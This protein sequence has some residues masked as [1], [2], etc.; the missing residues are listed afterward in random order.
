MT[1]V[2]T[3]L[4]AAVAAGLGAWLYWVEVPGI[5]EEARRELLLEID[6]DQVEGL[7]L[8]YPEGTAIEVVRQ[9]ES[10]TM[11]EPV[12]YAADASVVR[13]FLTTIQEAKIDRRLAAGESEALASYG[14]EGETGAQARIEVTLEGGKALPAVVLGNTTPVGYQAFARREDSDEVFVIPLLLQSSAK[15][16]PDDL[17]KKTMFDADST[18]VR[19]VTIEKPTERIELERRDDGSWAMLAPLSD[20]ADDEAVRSLL[21]SMATIDALAFFDGDAVD[22]DAFGLDEGA[23][24]FTAERDEGAD[25]A[26]TIGAPSTDPPAG[27]Y[28]ERLSDQQVVKAPDWVVT[29]FAPPAIELRDRRLVSCTADHIRS[30]AWTVD[31][32]S[33]TI[34]RDGSGNSGW[35]IQPEIADQV[36]NQRIVNNAV[37]GLVLARADAVVGDAA[38]DEELKTW[39][40]DQP[41]ARLEIV[42][43]D[44][45]CATLTGVRAPEEAAA[46]AEEEPRRPAGPQAFYVRKDGRS[47]VLRASEHEYKRL[48]MKRVEFVD[49]A[50]TDNN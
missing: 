27:N 43:A 42:G 28:F 12:D 47:A 45:P 21:D 9:G 46:A 13:N 26:F 24:R 33:F 7:R 40:L 44:G 49:A 11:T 20:A 25:V 48:A 15:K 4:L 2:R 36:L 22:R 8:A 10:W 18:G 50:P 29:K 41:D 31:G 32:E 16:E 6:P 34:S 5:Q 39:G 35:T 1:F 17:R 37:D 23:I 3:L 19:R 38:T 14:L 30:L